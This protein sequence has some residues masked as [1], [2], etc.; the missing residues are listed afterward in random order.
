[1]KKFFVFL[2]CVFLIAFAASYTQAAQFATRIIFG[3]RSTSFNDPYFT[4][5]PSGVDLEFHWKETSGKT[6]DY[7]FFDVICYSAYG[8]TG[9]EYISY[10]QRSTPAQLAEGETP[11]QKE[12]TGIWTVPQ[13]SR[14]YQDADVSRNCFCKMRVFDKAKNL[15]YASPEFTICPRDEIPKLLPMI[16][17]EA[18]T[19]NQSLGDTTFRASFYSNGNDL[20]EPYIAWDLF[21]RE[22]LVRDGMEN[23]LVIRID[24]N[25]STDDL[26]PVLNNSIYSYTTKNFLPPLQNYCYQASAWNKNG[27]FSGKSICDINGQTVFLYRTKLKTLSAEKVT[28]N[29]AVLSME[30]VDPGDD[31]SGAVPW[32]NYYNAYDQDNV[33]TTIKTPYAA[34]PKF[35]KAGKHFAQ[36]TGLQPCTPYCFFALAHTDWG[37]SVDK[38]NAQ[39]FTTLGDENCQNWV[40][41][42]VYDESTDFF[43][44]KRSDSPELVNKIRLGGR[45]FRFD[46]TV[47][48]SK[49]YTYFYWAKYQDALRNQWQGPIPNPKI[50]K[51]IDL[52][53]EPGGQY[54][55][56][57]LDVEYNQKYCWKAAAQNLGRT[58]QKAYDGYQCSEAVL[59]LQSKTVSAEGIGTTKARLEGE[60]I[61]SGGNRNAVKAWFEY[62]PCTDK[63]Q[64]P[65]PEEIRSLQ[66]KAVEIFYY[67][68]KKDSGKVTYG[69]VVDTLEE[70][71]GQYCFRSVVANSPTDK[72]TDKTNVGIFKTL[73]LPRIQTCK[74]F[75]PPDASTP[76]NYLPYYYTQFT[77]FIGK[78]QPEPCGLNALNF[79][80]DTSAS[81]EAKLDEQNIY[82]SS[83]KTWFRVWEARKRPVENITDKSDIFYLADCSIEPQ[84]KDKEQFFEA[85]TG[86]RNGLYYFGSQN[87]LKPDTEYCVQAVG[88]NNAGTTYGEII[89]FKTS[90]A[91]PTLE[92]DDFRIKNITYPANSK[93]FSYNV[94]GQLLSDG[95]TTNEGGSGALIWAYWWLEGEPVNTKLNP[96]DDP[97][98][99]KNP[100]RV[101]FSRAEKSGSLF[102]V[103]IGNDH[104]DGKKK[105]FAT[106]IAENMGKYGDKKYS[107]PVTK[108]F[109]IESP[110][111]LT[112]KAYS[113]SWQKILF[114]GAAKTL[115]KGNPQAK[116]YFNICSEEP[117]GDDPSIS[118]DT[119]FACS[120]GLRKREHMVA[121]P[122]EKGMFYYALNN[123]FEDYVSEKMKNQG[124]PVYEY[125]EVKKK[126]SRYLY[127]WQ[128]CVATDCTGNNT[129]SCLNCGEPK[130][131]ISMTDVP[132]FSQ[133][134]GQYTSCRRLYATDR[135]SVVGSAGCGDSALSM[136]FAYWYRN[137]NSFRANWQREYNLAI[138][139]CFYDIKTNSCNDDWKPYEK[140]DDSKLSVEER[141]EKYEPTTYKVLRYLTCKGL[142]SV[143]WALSGKHNIF[144]DFQTNLGMVF[145]PITG[146]SSM[147]DKFPDR[148]FVNW[149][150]TQRFTSRGIPI[151]MR[152]YGNPSHYVNI[153]RWDEYDKNSVKAV[154]NDSIASPQSPRKLFRLTTAVDK[155][156]NG[157]LSDSCGQNVS[158]LSGDQTYILFPLSK[159]AEVGEIY[160]IS[161]KTFKDFNPPE[162]Q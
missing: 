67:K 8:Y 84:A 4:F 104:L 99:K 3:N 129:F 100:H 161:R 117:A 41:N 152:C 107:L 49:G 38:K 33:S 22:T 137:D 28:R 90:F 77:P 103:L 57:D 17:T 130:S 157:R 89:P 101:T 20:Q 68:Q 6:A 121:V 44:L 32:F 36:I 21:P 136:S 126:Y 128:A 124:L 132:Q 56:T 79:I 111:A 120:Q 81:F 145:M 149:E 133:T 142:F 5:F 119:R 70:G 155:N 95:N 139:G 85:K 1:M 153:S 52:R 134:S 80:K 60:I 18:T 63:K 74:F 2:F 118:F 15:A 123:P 91:K 26:P 64:I 19:Q 54:F 113:M 73:R 25:K 135:M 86:S 76:Q 94:T 29:S 125:L 10:G 55:T 156:Y 158:G 151:I 98:F 71:G 24:P 27:W 144:K 138:R 51:S 72:Y 112:L 37:Y 150:Q 69:V 75:V 48:I 39:C 97:F 11:N 116:Y 9:Q 31:P 45:I 122:A 34:N 131:I 154:G 42:E 143:D 58:E 35:T 148:Q 53:T 40:K 147:G 30:I 109:N 140:I 146:S 162:L 23:S 96:K 14:T 83:F 62:W 93:T 106:L 114:S 110:Q 46:Q 7:P 127:K 88:A 43:Y 59:P 160:D 50:L 108:E 105:F 61:S 102:G 82:D 13:D 66:D 92:A 16:N 159:L 12:M 47:S 115:G 141:Y 65:D 87:G 78:S